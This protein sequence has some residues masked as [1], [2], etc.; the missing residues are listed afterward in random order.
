MPYR[1][2]THVL[3]VDA[4]VIHKVDTANPANLY[5]MWTVFSRCA[6]SVEQGRRLENLSW[7]LWQREQLLE[8]DDEAKTHEISAAATATT[9]TQTLPQDVP[10]EARLPDVPQLSG[11]V[12]SLED[13]AVEF[14]SVSAP[15]EIRPRIRRMDSSTSSRSKRDRHISSDDFEKMIVSIVKDKAPLSAP[16]TQQTM[17]PAATF[18][19]ATHKEFPIPAPAFERSGS[20]TTESQSPS[21][22]SDRQSDGSQAS[23]PRPR[24]ANVVRGFSPAA[25]QLTAFP[26]A[27]HDAIPEPSSSPAA[28]PVQPKKQ[29][30]RFALGGSCSSSEQGQSVDNLKAPVPPVAAAIAAKKSMFT[31]GG[32]SGE[33]SSLKSAIASPRPAGL[34]KKQASFSNHVTTRTIDQSD[35]AIDSDTEAEYVDESAIDDDD[36]SSD[37]EDSV[38]DSAKSSVAEENMFQRVPSKANLTSRPSLISIMMAQNDRAKALGNHASQSTSAIPR[39]RAGPS[40][41]S[42]GGSP[43]DSDEAPLMMKGMRHHQHHA[44]KPI[45][46]IP[47]SSAQPIVAA[48]NHVHAQAALSPRTTRRNMLATE[49]TESLRRHLLWERQQKS[50]TANAVLKRRHTSHDVANLKQYPEK[51]CMKDKEDDTTSW[52]QYFSKEALNG[53]HSKGW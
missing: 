51:A 41:P 44:L 52:N 11:S 53:Y 27:T 5:S 32:S 15:L 13:E 39:T 31:L 2:D 9:A 35:P 33:E 29:P 6:D 40:A 36:D 26:Q 37:W 18:A 10:S 4:N 48:P 17:T 47:R 34:A 20:T 50:S 30:A 43:N 12:D 14:T 25:A 42:L 45:S 1:L 46:E 7:R 24:A 21:K 49:L 19:P 22:D 16:T 3:T 23:P 28:K 38:E 8:N